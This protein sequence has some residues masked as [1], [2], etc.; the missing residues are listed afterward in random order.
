MIEKIEFNVSGQIT[1]NTYNRAEYLL[2]LEKSKKENFGIHRVKSW[3]NN[4]KKMTTEYTGGKP[5][6]F[7][8]S[9]VK[10]IDSNVV[11]ILNSDASIRFTVSIP[12][13]IIQW[14]DYEKCFGKNKFFKKEDY[15][16][17]FE[18]IDEDYYQFDNKFYS[19][20]VVSLEHK[21][22]PFDAYIQERY[23]DTET[24]VFLPFTKRISRRNPN[25]Y[26]YEELTVNL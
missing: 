26:S 21:K 13:E 5:S 9:V 23:L 22:E 1:T 8:D 20:I 14:E 7:W 6:Y 19:I 17:K 15:K 18:R 10:I 24:G 2:Y 3:M 12:E 25:Q 16:V 4:G 11:I